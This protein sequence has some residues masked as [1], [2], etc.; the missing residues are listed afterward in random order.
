MLFRAQTFTRYVDREEET[1]GN[2]DDSA[3]PKVFISHAGD[4]KDRFAR[5][6]AE[7][8]RENGVD[9]WFDE[10]EMLPGDSLVERLFQEGI[11]KADAFVI[12][13]SDASIDQEWVREE[14]NQAVVRKIQENARVIPIVLDG[15]EVPHPLRET[16][17]QSIP[18]VDAY[19]DEF[20]RIL[21][22]IFQERRKPEIGEPPEL[23][24]EPH[25]HREGQGRSERA[26]EVLRDEVYSNMETTF[27]V[28]DSLDHG[29][30]RSNISFGRSAWE[31][32]NSRLA[33]LGFP[34]K[35][36]ARLEQI[37]RA[38][39][40]IEDVLPGLDSTRAWVPASTFHEEN[41]TTLKEGEEIDAIL[42]GKCNEVFQTVS[43][44]AGRK[45]R[46][47]DKWVPPP[48]ERP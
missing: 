35:D 9:A 7:R 3:P 42:R 38:W 10:W 34:P 43:S 32:F 27:A 33:Q 15:V 28:W 13:L 18:D 26:F 48:D 23:D 36:Q 39:G 1:S 25:K 20:E 21:Q 29:R 5:E 4:D 11:G 37:Y 6:F 2:K 16:V 31:R 40:E 14:L 30:R 22:G 41:D 44:L 24:L 8:L 19:D 12:I 17:W 47:R 45:D 46:E